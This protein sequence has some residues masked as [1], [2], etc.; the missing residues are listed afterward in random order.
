MASPA[1]LD[2]FWVRE[3]NLL[4]IGGPYQIQ[5]INALDWY[6]TEGDGEGKKV[7]SL[8]QDDP[9]GE[10]GQAGLEFA[11]E[12]LDVELADP[13]R[14]PAPPAP[15]GDFTARRSASSRATAARW[16]SSWPRRRPRLRP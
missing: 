5:A 10:A 1:S 16:C 15:A 7:C 3:P 14:F 2:S 11:A 13:V 8:I 12:E 4:P 6:V 9:Y